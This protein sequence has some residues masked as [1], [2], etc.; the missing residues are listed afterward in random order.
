MQTPTQTAKAAYDAFKQGNIPGVLA[1]LSEDVDWEPI[2]GAAEHVPMR[3][4]RHG[5]QQVADFFRILG[6]NTT[7]TEFEPVEYIEQGDRVAIIG[8]YK[9]R[10]N[11]TNRTFGSDWV[12]VM[13]VRN[14][15]ITH[16]REYVDCSSIN[17]AHA[18]VTAG[19]LV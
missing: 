11:T 12:M 18:P 1:L 4:R 9:G 15:K 19:A 5:N 16:F 7:F 6:E 10:A 14:G 8:H 3:G 2:V 17:A 13:T